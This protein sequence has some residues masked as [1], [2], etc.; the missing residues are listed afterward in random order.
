MLSLNIRYVGDGPRCYAVWL[1]GR[2]VFFDGL[3][4]L[5]HIGDRCEIEVSYEGC[6]VSLYDFVR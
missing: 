3:D 2:P 4:G 1:D 6:H 5:P